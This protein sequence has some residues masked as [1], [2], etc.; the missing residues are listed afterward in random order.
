[1]LLPPPPGR[2]WARAPADA[3]LIPTP[4]LQPL[5]RREL[6]V[7]LKLRARNL[8]MYEVAE[9]AAHAA[10]AAVQATARLAEI[11]DGRQ[12]AINGAGGVPA[13]VEVV[14]SLLCAVFVF[15]PCVDVANKV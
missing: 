8:T 2:L 3:P 10:L 12:F 1:M 14:A 15:E 6:Q 5:L 4:H 11:G 13:R 7:A 9:A